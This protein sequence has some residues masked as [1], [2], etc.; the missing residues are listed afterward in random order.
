MLLL[1]VAH[2]GF[3]MLTIMANSFFPNVHCEYVSMQEF[4]MSAQCNPLSSYR[5]IYT[6]VLTVAH[7]VLVSVVRC[8]HLSG[9]I[10]CFCHSRRV[11]R[12]VTVCCQL[13]KKVSNILQISEAR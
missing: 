10:M 4:A 9:K 7:L 5:R 11:K 1:V 12:L 6:E 2:N 13:V 3:L 8:Q